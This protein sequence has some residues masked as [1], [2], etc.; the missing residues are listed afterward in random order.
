MKRWIGVL[1]VCA[2]VASAGLLAIT[3]ASGDGSHR[4]R[5]TR[6]QHVIERDMPRLA[7][8]GIYVQGTGIAASCVVVSVANPTAPNVDYLR[9]RYGEPMC[10]ERQ[11]GPLVACPG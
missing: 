8:A 3:S 6:L 1:L 5:R 10:V 7:R 4:D 9:R 2:A 11:S